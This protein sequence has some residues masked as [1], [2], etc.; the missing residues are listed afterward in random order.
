MRLYRLT[1]SLSF[2]CITL[3]SCDRAKSPLLDNYIGDYHFNAFFEKTSDSLNVFTSYRVKIERLGED[4]FATF[5]LQTVPDGKLDK[6][7]TQLSADKQ[8]II[9]YF[10]AAFKG[11]LLVIGHRPNERQDTVKIQVSVANNF[12]IVNPIYAQINK[13]QK[14]VLSGYSDFTQKV[15]WY[16]D[17]VSDTNGSSVNDTLKTTIGSAG[18]RQVWASIKDKNGN[19]VLSDTAKI[20]F[21]SDTPAIK[22]S[23]N[24]ENVSDSMKI[25]TPY[26]IIIGQ[27]TDTLTSLSLETIPGDKLDTTVSKSSADKKFITAYFKAPL[28]GEL[29]V[30]GHH[31]NNQLD[32]VKIPVSVVND[33]KITSPKIAQINK[34][35]TI[36]IAGYY[37]PTLKVTWYIDNNIVS[38]SK[39]NDTLVTTFTS[40][41]THSI[42]AS[43]KDTNHNAVSSDTVKISIVPKIPS[44]K[45][46]SDTMSVKACDPVTLDITAKDCDSVK[47]DF[48]GTD[49]TIVTAGNK[50]ETR[51]RGNVSTDT[52]IA[53]G[54]VVQN[55][56][57][58]P[59]TL[60]IKLIQ[61]V[62]TLGW[63][64]EKSPDTVFSGKW[65]KWDVKA[66]KDGLP[67]TPS[68]VNYVW[69]MIPD[70]LWDSSKTSSS[71]DTIGLFFADSVQSFN[72]RVFGNITDAFGDKHRTDTL[73]KKVIVRSS[74]P[75]LTSLTV[76]T[77]S[78]AIFIKDIRN[79]TVQGMSP[80]ST[81]DSIIAFWPDGNSSRLSTL[82]GKAVF[83]HLFQPKDTGKQ[84]LKF[85]GYDNS[86]SI[87][88]TLYDTIRVRLGAP[89]L[90]GNSSG[91][92]D[93]IFIVVNKGYSG[94]NATYF[95][96][97]NSYDTNGTIKKYYWSNNPWPDSGS[98]EYLDSMKFDVG[99]ARINTGEEYYVNCRDDDG[100]ING[101]KFV[102]FADSAPPAP[103]VFDRQFAG[104]SVRLLWNKVLD[105]KDSLETQ[106]KIM[107]SYG[108]SGEPDQVLLPYQS[109]GK[110]A[111]SG[112]NK[113]YFSYTFKPDAQS[114][115]SVRWRVWLMDSRGSES[116]GSDVATFILP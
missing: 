9:A 67:I 38:G 44:V 39:L 15:T 68:S 79:F 1:I 94:A 107:I 105:K 61:P 55:V 8:S 89:V 45:F 17:N 14:I 82:N 77:I 87:T 100:V 88:D 81:L 27:I 32:T 103:S 53:R 22:L 25:F 69:N 34:E 70:S 114:G 50:I 30:I 74:K 57:C 10:K 90:W 54:I 3:L 43:I 2:L 23:A 37:D 104:D 111:T 46:A 80:S 6:N 56:P 95:A 91:K 64:K 12:K 72:L 112:S 7:A 83:S 101:G 11:T 21:V 98:G 28:S 63:S 33:F 66:S 96:H 31:Q 58:V 59:D 5:S 99:K 102:I 92:R 62:Y 93:T 71:G 4:T 86:H 110:F 48:K 42:R 35:Q 116:A 29:F 108:S 60:I 49:T 24:F 78:S 19:I 73:D 20:S 76:D 41:D 36:L 109:A 75:K 51:F 52:V 26:K 85:I 65:Y 106:I 115:S 84:T 16:I 97:V 18:S 13:E 40:L 113:E 47:W